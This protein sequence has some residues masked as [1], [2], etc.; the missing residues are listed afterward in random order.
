MRCRDTLVGLLGSVLFCAALA[1]A[2]AEGNA[3][4]FR[5]LSPT[6]TVITA[7]SPDGMLVWS[8][9]AMGVT[10]RV[11]RATTLLGPSNWVN[12]AG[13]TATGT[14]MA[15]PTADYLVVDLSGGPSAPSYPVSSLSAVP[16]GGWTD[17]YK[18]TKLVLR[19]IP[20]G[21]FVMGS[22]TDELGRYSDETQHEVTL[23]QPFYI[24]IFEVTQKQWERV[25][26]TWPSYFNN[27]SYRDSRPVESVSYYEIRENPMPILDQWTKGSAISPNWPQSSQVHGDSFMGRL[28][29]R[30]GR[31]FDLPTESQWEY[32]GRAGTTTALNSGKNLTSTGS[33][34]NMSEVGRYWYNGGSSYGQTVDTSGGTAKVG[35]YLPNAWG[36]YDVHGNV[37]EWCLDWYGDYPGTVSDPWGPSAGQFGSYRVFR[38]G[39]WYGGGGALACS[40][41]VGF[42]NFSDPRYAYVFI[43]FR[44]VLPLGQ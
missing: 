16:A 4:Y 12:F 21:T 29:A 7:F 44:T 23:T 28:R 8:N 3:A 9:A 25:M 31:A 22:P 35:T 30:T 37:W 19:R 38:G 43:G 34:P 39:S 10:G 26:G 20:A 17:V 40:C 2:Q 27:A 13:Y 36:L 15:L 1:T 11:Q 32:A 24:G 14:V 41:R 18:T 6:T 33:C 42:R 5:I